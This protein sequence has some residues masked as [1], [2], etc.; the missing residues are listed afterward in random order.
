[1][2]FYMSPIYNSSNCNSNNNHVK[3]VYII[4]QNQTYISQNIT[5]VAQHDKVLHHICCDSHAHR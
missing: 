1:M 4:Y 2:S 3:A 5:R